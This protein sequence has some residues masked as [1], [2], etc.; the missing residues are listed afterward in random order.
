M[1]WS[2][3]AGGAL[4]GKIRRDK[5]APKESRLGQSTFVP[6]DDEELFKTVDALELIAKQRNK[7]IAQVALNWVLRKPSVANIVI[8]ARTEEQLLQNL[9]AL[10]WKLSADEVE[11]LD[12]ASAPR[13]P[14]PTGTK[15]GFRC[16]CRAYPVWRSDHGECAEIDKSTFSS[17]PLHF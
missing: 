6:Y 4:T 12:R 9:G 17:A 3:L 13:V 10:D 8:G 14:Y 1:V 2:P 11:L 5:P 7:S 15:S 16:W